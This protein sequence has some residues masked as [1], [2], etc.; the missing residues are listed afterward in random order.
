M[1]EIMSVAGLCITV[2]LLC[3]VI[4]KYNS[5]QAVITSIAVITA[6]LAAVFVMISPVISAV[7]SIFE[8]SGIEDE[9]IQIIFKALGISYV[10]QL[11]GDICRDCG[12]NSIASS[13]ETAGKIMLLIISLPLFQELVSIVNSL[14]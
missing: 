14:L 1:V 6:V 3:R 9:N 13:A 5:E 2:S 7:L 4:G 8:R 12:E 10:T 11:T